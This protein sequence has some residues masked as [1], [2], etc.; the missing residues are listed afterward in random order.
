MLDFGHLL[1]STKYDVQLF[2][3]P[4]T[5]SNNQWQT[6][7]RPRG[8]SMLHI[9][10]VGG[11][12]GGGGGFTGATTTARGGGGG[13]GG[14][15]IVRVTIP[16]LVLPDRLYIQSG[17]GGIGQV[18][19]GGTAGS[20]IVSI[21]A[22]APDNNQQ[23]NCL[24]FSGSAAPTGGATGTVAAGGAAGG[25]GTVSSLATCPLAG[26]GHFS[27]LVGQAGAAGGA[28]T[29]AAGTSIAFSAG[30]LFTMGAPGGAGVNAGA[31]TFAGGGITSQGS[32]GILINDMRPLPAAAGS[33]DGSSGFLNW[34]PLWSYCG[35]GGSSN[36]G[37]VGGNG[38]NGGPGSG[39]AGGGAGT[40]GGKGGD[41]G[42][43]FVLMVAW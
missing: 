12:G 22:V 35:L 39:G 32:V 2:N 9:L 43:G 5:V 36:D 23:M 18:S 26:Y 14:S 25:G 28:Q 11:G 6:W 13:G 31:A 21:V 42:N 4:S 34:K 38:G 33:N 30:G 8:C 19:G 20:G 3:S 7:Q 17:A 40:T 10:C 37:G 1:T 41:G 27:A 16:L 29:G 15:P 24:A